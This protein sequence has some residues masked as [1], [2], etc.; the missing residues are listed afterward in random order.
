M[1]MLDQIA[2]YV[3]KIIDPDI[4]SKLSYAIQYF[5]PAKYYIL[6][7]AVATGIPAF[8]LG[9][10]AFFALRM[11]PPPNE[12]SEEPACPSEENLES[13]TY[14]TDP[15]DPISS[16]I[17]GAIKN[18]RTPCWVKVGRDPVT[19][20]VMYIATGGCSSPEMAH[21]NRVRNGRTW[22]DDQ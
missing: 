17:L 20:H 16:G 2:P 6:S 7:I 18:K 4:S 5:E 8:I 1:Y 21:T 10:G 3:N 12:S 15:D 11:R 13:V 22:L 19:G 14:E 9:T